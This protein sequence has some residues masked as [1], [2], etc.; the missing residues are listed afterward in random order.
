MVGHG[1]QSSD[2]LLTSIGSVQSQESNSTDSR[3]KGWSGQQNS[4]SI[5]KQ[6][7]RQTFRS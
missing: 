7:K 1:A 4:L 3:I 2:Q 6:E 5:N